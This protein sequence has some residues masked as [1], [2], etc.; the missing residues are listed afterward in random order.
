MIIFIQE[1]SNILTSAKLNAKGLRWIAALANFKFRIHYC[2]RAKN[3]DANYLL[4]HTIAET[5]QKESRH[6]SI[7]EP[8][9]IRLVPTS[10]IKIHIPSINVDKYVLQLQNS[11]DIT[12]ITSTQLIDSRQ[13]DIS[14]TAACQFVQ[15][16]IKSI[17]KT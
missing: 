8:N 16:K 17:C 5:E 4:R 2:N 1:S 14:I 7:N 9:N 13:Q 3:K 12:S 15:L 6:H 10:I 11:E